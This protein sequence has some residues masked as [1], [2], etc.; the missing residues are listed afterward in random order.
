MNRLISIDMYADFG[1]LK[2]PDTNDPVYLTFNMLHKPSLLGILGAIVGL[3]GFSE[4]PPKPKKKKGKD[5]STEKESQRIVA[6]YYEALKDLKIGIRPLRHE[7]GNFSKT[8]L[9]YNNGVGYANI[10][11]GG[12]TNLMVTEQMLIEPGYRCY[13]LFEKGD[14]ISQQLFNNLKNRDAEFLPYLGKNEFSAWWENW[15]E[16]RFKE[17]EPEG[18]SFEIHSVFM[19]DAPVKSGKERQPY[20]VASLPNFMYFENL[21]IGYD[22][23]IMQYEY[24]AFAYTNCLLKQDYPVR[25]LVQLTEIEPNEIVQLF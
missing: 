20:K 16:Y 21:P 5:L 11:A 14:E 3:E 10:Q 17:F 18:K 12:P 8:I 9:T 6:P 2:K 15:Q 7:N 13:I 23:Q 22:I 24:D 4:P 25:N 1:C 19:K